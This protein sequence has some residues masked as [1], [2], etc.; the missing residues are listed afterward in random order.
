[1]QDPEKP[2]LRNVILKVKFKGKIN[3]QKKKKSQK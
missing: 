2:I 1:M 3:Y